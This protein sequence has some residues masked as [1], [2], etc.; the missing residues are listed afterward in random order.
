MHVYIQQ[1]NTYLSIYGAQ[2]KYWEYLQ[3]WDH[4]VSLFFFWREKNGD[5]N[6]SPDHSI[7]LLHI[8]GSYEYCVCVCVCVY[9]CVC[10]CVC[11]CVN[12]CVCV[13]F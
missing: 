2:G 12:V 4:W 8:W 1:I 7:S 6:G 10:V 9:V 11:M 13:C 3:D 5:E